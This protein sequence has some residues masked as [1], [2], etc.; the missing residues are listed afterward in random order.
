M[1]EAKAFVKTL[2]QKLTRTDADQ[3]ANLMTLN[4]D[5]PTTTTLIARCRDGDDRAWQMLVRRFARLVHSIP[6]RHG[7][8]PAEVDDV[9]QEVFVALAQQLATIEDPERLPGWLATTARRISWQVMRRRTREAPDAGEDLAAQEVVSGRMVAAAHL[10]TISEVLTGWE[11]QEALQ[12]G[13]AALGERCRMLLQAIFLDAAEPTYDEIS[14]Q[15]GLPKG[16]IGP[17]R[18]RCL[19]QLR[20]ILIGLGHGEAR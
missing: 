9:G 3:G 16:S 7:L 19:A 18:N 6:V 14:A 13:F 4:S 2:D 20:E 15:L 5:E 11:R 12:A 8:T 1:L 10:P 17:T